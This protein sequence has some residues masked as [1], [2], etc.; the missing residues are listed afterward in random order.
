M[1]KK[2]KKQRHISRQ[3]QEAITVIQDENEDVMQLNEDQIRSQF[4][5]EY[6]MKLIELEHEKLNTSLTIEDK[7]K[8][9]LLRNDDLI[10]QNKQLQQQVVEQVAMIQEQQQIA[11][12]Q[13]RQFVHSWKPGLM[14]MPS[15]WRVL[16]FA[17]VMI[18]KQQ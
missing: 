5:K 9:V 18:N 7:M 8:Q 13:Q 3:F 16:P 6:E 15:Y 2:Y 10:L 17:V 11:L 4:E 12:R 1:K 14:P